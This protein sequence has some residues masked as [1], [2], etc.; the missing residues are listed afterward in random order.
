[1]R[2]QIGHPLSYFQNDIRG[3]RAKGRVGH[4]TSASLAPCRTH[5]Q[6]RSLQDAFGDR[7]PR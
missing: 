7:R 1:M 5:A 2:L 4:V 3:V 6:G